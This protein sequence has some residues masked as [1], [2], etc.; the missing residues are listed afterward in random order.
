MSVDLTP[1]QEMQQR[2][3]NVFGTA[4]GRIV[5][6]D[7]A[8][9]GHVFDTIDPTSVILT[10]ERNFA[11]VILQMAGALDTLYSQLGMARQTNPT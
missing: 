4:E 2:Y 7:I 1:E 10:S 6:G 5:L 9:V 3:R 11:L 8:T